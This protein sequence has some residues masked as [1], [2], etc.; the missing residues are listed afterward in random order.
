MGLCRV[1][2]LGPQP[3]FRTSLRSHPRPR[4]PQEG[5]LR[6]PFNCMWSASLPAQ[7][8]SVHPFTSVV[9]QSTPYPQMNLLFANLSVLEPVS[10]ELTQDMGPRLS[11][12]IHVKPR[13]SLQR[14]K[15]A[16]AMAAA[17]P[18]APQACLHTPKPTFRPHPLQGGVITRPFYRWRDQSSR[19]E[20]AHPRSWC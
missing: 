9:P 11:A 17:G 19:G 4:A 13:I 15:K 20:L 10:Q 5:R 14:L 12:P 1:Q 2:R 18:P 6:P 3:Q 7:A 8:C 16:L